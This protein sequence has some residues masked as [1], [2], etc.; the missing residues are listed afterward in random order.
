M[1]NQEP[2]VT[3][4]LRDGT[5]A[6]VWRE[7]VRIGERMFAAAD[8][9][10]ARQ[11]APD[12]ETVAL[13]VANERHVVEFQPAHYG[14]GVLLLEGLF[15]LRPELRPAGFEAPTTLPAGFPPLPNAADHPVTPN[16]WG[17]HSTW[18]PH[19]GMYVPPPPAYIPPPPVYGP[20]QVSVGGRLTSF[21]RGSGELI[22]ATFDLFVA[23][24][25]RWLLL[26]LV[27]LFLPQ[28]IPGAVDA[29]FH[30]LG[31]NDL[32]AGLPT[33]A[34][35][36]TNGT[37][38]VSGTALPSGNELLLTV[39]DLLITSAIGALIT[40]WSAA[41]L[42]IASRD[43]LFGHAPKV[44]ASMRVGLK[45][46]FPAVGASL[47]GFVLVLLILLPVIILYGV[48]LTQF[49]SAIADPTTIDPSSAAANVLGVLGCLTLILI[50][51]SV[52]LAI[53]VG[54]RLALAP[55][56]AAT[57]PVG[58][59]AAV[60]KSWR[61][62]RGL[63]WHTALPIFVIAVLVRIILIPAIFVQYASFGAATLVAIPL[64][65]ALTV[66]LEAIVAVTV[67]YDLR[68]RREGYASLAS[69]DSTGEEPV[70][71]SV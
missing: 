52:I 27:A 61:L 47:L 37:L 38:G 35:G 21:P 64:I 70:P 53:Y 48:I 6:S 7:G 32:W 17:M 10:D 69:E 68:L 2:F 19:P 62:T 45:R 22:R 8:I 44:G 71:T 23:H 42:G 20:P 25:R 18:P 1:M 28:I 46:L 51:P 29:V 34:G 58:S 63:W 31:G 54:V 15:R 24:W 57:E 5:Q 9:Q 40:G 66:P 26:G 30:V 55:Y 41:V 60:R 43:A 3:I 33:A 56:V 59:L 50:V 13:R 36:A 12:P 14:D 16:P 49:G 65:A 4:P 39:L 11:V 67:L